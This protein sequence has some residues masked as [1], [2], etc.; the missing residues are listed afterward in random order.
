L[1]KKPTTHKTI[2]PELSGFAAGLLVLV[3]GVLVAW[4]RLEVD[5][6]NELEE[7]D[8]VLDIIEQNMEQTMDEAY[9]AALI[10]ALAVNDNGQ[11]QNFEEL[12]KNLYDNQEAA[13]VL[14]LVP[15]GVIQYV[16]PLEGNEA[17]IGY[18]ILNDPNVNREAY[19]AAESSTIY[20][21]GPINLRQGGQAVIGRIPIFINDKFWGLSAVIVYLETLVEMSGINN[22]SDQYYFQFYKINPNTG[23]EEYFLPI[24][25]GRSFDVNHTVDF[26]EGDWKISASILSTDGDFYN[27]IILLGFSVL[28]AVLVGF[29]FYSNARKPIEL[30]EL[31]EQKS[32]ELIRSREQF[33]KNS[34]LLSSVLESPKNMV[35]FSLDRDYRYLAFNN[36]H[37]AIVKSLSRK[38]KKIKKGM[39]VFEGVSDESHAFLKEKYDRALNGE[40]FEYLMEYPDKDGSVSYWQN[41]FS[42]IRN[43]DQIIGLTVFSSDVTARINMEREIAKSEQRYRT[44]IAN[45]PFCIHELDTNGILISINRAG[46]DM[47]NQ[48]NEEDF[49]GMD[50]TK[51]LGE[52]ESKPVLALFGRALEGEI[53]EFEFSFGNKFFQ[54]S[55]VPIK[56]EDG[57]IVRVMG[58]TQDITERKKANEM[59]EE[60]LK[61]KTTLLSEIH[62]RVKNNLAIVS[63]LLELQKGEVNDDR[64]SVYFDQSINRIIS[65]AMVHELM[66]Q[67]HDL[68]SVDVHSYLEMLIPAISA[69]MQYRNKNVQFEIDIAEY[70]LNINEAI[71]LGLMLNE[72]I[73]N[74][75]KYA[76]NDDVDNIITI[77]VTAENEVVHVKYCDN[78]AGFKDGVDFDAP[79]NLGLTLVHAQLQQL[80]ASY[81]ATT[82]NQFCLDFSFAAKGRGSH[83]NYS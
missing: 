36:N 6:Q 26:P 67:T 37:K 65:I 81:Q 52:D 5:H 73:T 57:V 69:T 54:S 12:A 2:V 9:S 7:L 14:Q 77:N 34:E 64:L 45:S 78:G 58:I 47:F 38:P 60:S 66:Y 15:D 13:D 53:L 3:L 4:Q 50:Y 83:S 32:K 68:S 41:W 56:D 21:A 40:S 24:D 29:I 27:F 72:L 22:Y 49:L 61:E 43:G 75:F 79:K 71:P 8:Q 1:A 20:F 74:S 31:L 46:L 42:P 80:D 33:R 39:S 28:G 48:E 30:E 18:D 82:L 17:V 16:Y 70:K 76:F 23:E 11:V 51:L 62:H 44:L 19:M 55:F 59:I 63:G 35:I 25:D 10:L